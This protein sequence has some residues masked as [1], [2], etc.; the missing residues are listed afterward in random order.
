M[1]CKRK[2]EVRIEPFLSRTIE[3][4]NN[5]EIEKSMSV[6]K[7]GLNYYSNLVIK[8]LT[9]YAA[10]DAG[11]IVVTLRHIADEVEKD[12]D[13]TKEFVEK[14][15]KSLSF[16]AISQTERVCK[17]NTKWSGSEKRS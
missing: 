14:F 1:K 8:A 15:S 6:A 7:E 4:L 11:L 9:P 16:P 2:R 3:L 17:P 5:G 13:G 10:I 12:N